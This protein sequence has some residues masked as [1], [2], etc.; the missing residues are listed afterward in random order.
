MKM[1]KYVQLFESWINEATTEATSEDIE[2]LLASMIPII[3]KSVNDCIR[4]EMDY[5]KRLKDA[6]NDNMRSR[7]FTEMDEKIELAERPITVFLSSKGKVS[8]SQ[9]EK[10]LSWCK[11]MKQLLFKSEMASKIQDFKDVGVDVSRWKEMYN[12]SDINNEIILL[13][14]T[15][16][17]EMGIRPPLVAA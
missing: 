3:K 1:K 7:V 16:E 13:N 4:I 8:Q 11:S 5:A 9:F 14:K 12:P 15:F 17:K 2:K 6:E 10:I